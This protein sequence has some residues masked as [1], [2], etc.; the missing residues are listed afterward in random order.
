[1]WGFS[2]RR[3]LGVRWFFP[4]RQD[5]HSMQ[6]LDLFLPCTRASK[7]SDGIPSLDPKNDLCSRNFNSGISAPMASFA[8]NVTAQALTPPVEI[9]TQCRKNILQTFLS[10]LTRQLAVFVWYIYFD[11]S[12]LIYVYHY[13]YILD[14]RWVVNNPIKGDLNCW[15]TTFFQQQMM[16]GVRPFLSRSYFRK[17]SFK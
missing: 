9:K 10:I 17:K 12:I 14:S 11:T 6:S 1:M 3:S 8:K 16:P 15:A 5:K 7:P 4:L 2:N 13:I